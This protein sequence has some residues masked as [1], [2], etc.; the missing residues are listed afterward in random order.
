MIK[1]YFLFTSRDNEN[2]YY[3]SLY[4][5]QTGNVLS[6]NQIKDDMYFKGN[7]IV[8]YGGKPGA[9]LRSRLCNDGGDLIWPVQPKVLLDGY[10]AY[11]K[12]LTKDKWELFR[13]KYPRLVEVCEQLKHDDNPIL[14]K[15]KLKDF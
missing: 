6:G 8:L 2:K 10:E 1:Y 9:N 5:N 14:L 15:I 4:S 11:R 13:K 3:L 12:V 7:V